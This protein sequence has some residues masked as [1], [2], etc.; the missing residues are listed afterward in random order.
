MKKCN[1][2][3]GI[4]I[5]CMAFFVPLTANAE[6][7]KVFELVSPAFAAGEEIP[8]KYTCQGGDSNPPLEMKNLPPKTQ[9]LALTV[10]DPDAPE[11]V[12]VHWVVYNIAPQKTIVAEN[13]VPGYQALN[14]FGRYN[15]GGPCP[16][17]EK[18]HRY[19]FRAYALNSILE[20]NEGMTMKDLEKAMGGHTIAKSELTGTYRKP[21]W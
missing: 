17:D 20:I 16:Q 6:E 21:I 19:L 2:K 11:G 1:V 10:H 9:S 5:F 8:A 7:K 3:P 15:Y 14:D 13:S 18:L 4:F 12:W